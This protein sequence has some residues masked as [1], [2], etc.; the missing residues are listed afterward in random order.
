VA[1]TTDPKTVDTLLRRLSSM[2]D[3]AQ[4]RLFDPTKLAP[5]YTLAEV[6]R[7]FPFNAYYEQEALRPVDANGYTLALAGLIADKRPWSVA[8]LQAL[9]VTEQIT[10]HVCV[11]GWS[12]IGRW[13]GYPL[14]DFLR[15]VGADTRAKYVNFVCADDYHTSIDMATALH[16]QT[17]LA[18]QWD[19]RAIPD[20]YGFPFKVRIPTKL[21]FKNPKQVVAME[22]T[23]TYPGGFWEDQGY[24]W[25]AGL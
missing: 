19:G 23:N 10:R 13:G 15:R 17:L 1:L 3:G 12:A 25:F 7:P 11:E 24:N 6:V 18:T 20:A 4:A 21:G 14:G 16:P 22:V 8:D 5:T 2:N 9:P